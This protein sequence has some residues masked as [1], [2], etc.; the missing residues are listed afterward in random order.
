MSP[1][2]H[3]EIYFAVGQAVCEFVPVPAGPFVMGTH[4]EHVAA[5]VS[6]FPAVQPEWILKEVP[7]HEVYL[8]GYYIARTPI[9]NQLWQEYTERTGAPALP[10]WTTSVPRPN[11]PVSGITYKDAESFCNWL[12]EVSGYCLS[13]PSEAQW[14]KA[15]RGTSGREWPWGNDF[16]SGHCNTREGAY[17][18]VTAV[19][20]FPSGS[21]PYGILDMGGNVE[22]WTS[23]C[24]QP[25]PGGFSVTDGFGGPGQYRVTRGGHWEGGGDLA[26]C[27]RRHGTFPQSRVGARIVLTP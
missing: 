23:D 14:E 9:T 2:I 16:S 5:V 27:A 22:E 4:A 8:S 18:G 13:L 15:A 6:Q 1:T 17:G 12:S 25:Y 10:T 24:Y 11:H 3:G 19:D 26:R 7:E 21:S 20:R